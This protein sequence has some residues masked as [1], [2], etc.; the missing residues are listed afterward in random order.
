[1]A[2]AVKG[3]WSE[4]KLGIGPSIEDGFYYDFDTSAALSAGSAQP[5]G[6]SDFTRTVRDIRAD[7]TRI[8]LE[9]FS[10][11]KVFF[12]G[13]RMEKKRNFFSAIFLSSAFFLFFPL[14]SRV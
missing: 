7:I 14:A 1:M 5:D 6:Y 11:K 2:E 13:D 3:L 8:P 12:D 4:A 9:S 10:V